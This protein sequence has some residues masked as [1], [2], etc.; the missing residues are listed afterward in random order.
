MSNT[1]PPSADWV[2]MNLEALDIERAEIRHWQNLVP[3]V[4][5]WFVAG[6]FALSAFFFTRPIDTPRIQIR[7]LGIVVSA[8]IVILTGLYCKIV[9]MLRDYIESIHKTNLPTVEREL[10]ECA[11]RL[12]EEGR[13]VYSGAGSPV[14]QV[15]IP[16]LI[17]MVCFTGSIAALL[18]L[19]WIIV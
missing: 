6:I 7:A 2:N 10:A 3:T 14:R 5:F 16:W 15:H 11:K 19:V 9:A 8:T 18:V 4:T 1:Q 12:G 17:G 13:F